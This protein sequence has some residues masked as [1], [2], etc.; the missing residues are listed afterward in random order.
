MPKV[1]VLRNVAY[2]PSMESPRGVYIPNIFTD[3]EVVTSNYKNRV[4]FYD[5]GT[6][7][8]FGDRK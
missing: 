1:L 2:T 8:I 7:F 6:A 4:M 3:R 5:D